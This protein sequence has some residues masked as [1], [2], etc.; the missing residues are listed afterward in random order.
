MSTDDKSGKWSAPA[1]GDLGSEAKPLFPEAA[2]PVFPLQDDYHPL[3]V[4]DTA[5]ASPAY[6]SLDPEETF[7]A[8]FGADLSTEEEEPIISEADLAQMKVARPASPP[9]ELPL[10]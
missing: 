3:S 9:P 8:L 1:P 5:P 4:F 6:E 2:V 10:P 7:D